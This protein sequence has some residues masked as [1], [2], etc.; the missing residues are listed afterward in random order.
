VKETKLKGKKLH[1]Y[2]VLIVKT[3]PPMLLYCPNRNLVLGWDSYDIGKM[4]FRMAL[5]L[6]LYRVQLP[7]HPVI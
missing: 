6:R 7:W 4:T 2:C 1:Y 3:D 5:L